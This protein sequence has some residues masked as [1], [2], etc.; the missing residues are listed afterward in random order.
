[1]GYCTDLL[2]L[3]L[4]RAPKNVLQSKPQTP[5]WK[6]EP[7]GP[8]EGGKHQEELH[9]SQLVPWAHLMPWKQR[10]RSEGSSCPYPATPP[11]PTPHDPVLY[12]VPAENSK[13]ASLTIKFPF[14]SRK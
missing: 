6:L 11:L 10:E 12:P 1:M 7:K 2:G 4:Q 14:L 13:K 8:E 9:L 3:G 5:L